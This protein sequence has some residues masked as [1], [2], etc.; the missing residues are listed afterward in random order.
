MSQ[1][2]PPKKKDKNLKNIAMLS[3]IAF[4]MGAIIFLSAKGGIW[5]DEHYHNEKKIFTAITTIIGVAVAIWV[6]L[7]QIKRIKY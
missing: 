3:G 5:L 4:E 1:Q 2:K 6:V 7:R